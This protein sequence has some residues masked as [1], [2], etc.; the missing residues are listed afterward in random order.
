[1]KFVYTSKLGQNANFEQAEKV[2]KAYR[3]GEEIKVSF[4][5]NRDYIA[6]IKTI[7]GHKWHPEGSYWS[8][9]YSDN[10]TEEIM[11][12]FGDEGVE[13]DPSLYLESLRRELV[14]RKYSQ[15][16]I[17]SY[18]HYNED[19]LRFAGKN[20]EE[21]VNGDVK[22]YLVYLTEK[23]GVSTSSLNI[24]ISALKFYYA[25]VRKQSF[26][27]EIKRP[28]KDNKL[29]TV[30]NGSDVA[31]KTLKVYIEATN[32]KEWLFPGQKSGS[33]ISTRTAQQIFLDAVK[34]AGIMKDVSIHSLRHSF[35]THL[36]ESG[37]DLRY[38]Q[39][40]LGHKN[41]KTTEIYTHV[42]NLYMRNIKSPLDNILQKGAE[43]NAEDK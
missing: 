27:Y 6:R 34:A 38:I 24:A 13:I 40:L 2:I 3:A 19:F 14:S 8:V 42:S 33:H 7:E 26:V 28:T 15:K 23:K 16:T 22:D 9:P 20:P 39:E 43:S 29:P 1:M 31:Q 41:N 25:E 4:P 5:Y 21:I 10:V 36:L 11:S 32:P 37:V 35:T 30:L 17:K 18:I 12:I